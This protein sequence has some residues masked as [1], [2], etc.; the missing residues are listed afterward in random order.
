VKNSVKSLIWQYL[1][2]ALVAAIITYF[3][4]QRG[5]LNNVRMIYLTVLALAGALLPSVDVIQTVTLMKYGLEG[6]DPINLTP[7]EYQFFFLIITHIVYTALAPL[8]A[9]IGRSADRVWARGGLVLLVSLE[10]IIVVTNF[11]GMKLSGLV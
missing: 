11:I 9:W 10:T 5:R 8:M 6:S 1:L 4:Y 7:P 2:Y 3:L